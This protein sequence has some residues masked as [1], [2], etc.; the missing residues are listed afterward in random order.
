VWPL[1]S[2]RTFAKRIAN[3]VTDNLADCI[4][5][6]GTHSFANSFADTVPHGFF[7]VGTDSITVSIPDHI[8]NNL[9]SSPYLIAFWLAVDIALS[10]PHYVANSITNS[11]NPC[12]DIV[13]W[14]STITAPGVTRK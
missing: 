9:T 14:S 13:H 7:N 8:A 11:Q 12:T 2:R 4:T 5:N 3:A 10:E 1:Q 6:S